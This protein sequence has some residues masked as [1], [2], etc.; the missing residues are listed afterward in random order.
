MLLGAING[1]IWG[2]QLLGEEVLGSIPR[3]RMF[4]FNIFYEQI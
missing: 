3:G 2:Q 4:F 1:N